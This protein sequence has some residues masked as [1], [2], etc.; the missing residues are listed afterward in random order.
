MPF[1]LTRENVELF[2]TDKTDNAD[3]VLSEVKPFDRD[4]LAEY[5]QERPDLQR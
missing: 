5:E 3:S 4:Q 1:S 2:T